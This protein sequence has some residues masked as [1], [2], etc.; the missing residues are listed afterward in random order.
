MSKP[1][2]LSSEAWIREALDWLRDDVAGLANRAEEYA[3]Y[4]TL[5]PKYQRERDELRALIAAGEAL[6]GDEER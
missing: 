6:I 3:R 4:P 5:G 2:P 1:E